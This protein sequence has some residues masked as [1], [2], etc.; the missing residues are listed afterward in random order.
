M[1]TG[2]TAGY[3]A[4]AVFEELV[5]VEGGAAELD[6]LIACDRGLGVADIVDNG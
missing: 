2:G 3:A 4:G 5:P 6:G 1:G